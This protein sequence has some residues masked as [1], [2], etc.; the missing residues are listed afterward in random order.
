MNV[1][2]RECTGCALCA[3]KCPRRAITM[4]EN[5]EGFLYPVIDIK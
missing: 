5:E 1:L 2:D 4:E 3:S